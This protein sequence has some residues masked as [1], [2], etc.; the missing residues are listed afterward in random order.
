MSYISQITFKLCGAKLPF[1]LQSL[2]GWN[3]ATHR[4][5]L[6]MVFKLLKCLHRVT[7]MTDG[8]IYYMG[9]FSIVVCADLL[10]S[11][12]REMSIGIC[13]LWTTPPPFN[14]EISPNVLNAV[15]FLFVCKSCPPHVYSSFFFAIKVVLITLMIKTYSVILVLFNWLHNIMAAL[16]SKFTLAS[17]HCDICLVSM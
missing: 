4:M 1:V 7:F 9:M 2:D 12:I 5:F 10:S 14:L 17:R 15:I 6:Q 16:L 8:L 13:L 11:C 3:T